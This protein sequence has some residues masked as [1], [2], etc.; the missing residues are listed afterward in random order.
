MKVFRYFLTAAVCAALL[1]TACKSQ[2]QKAEDG[3]EP[4]VESEVTEF[5]E[6][7]DDEISAAIRDMYLNGRFND[8]GYLEE[9]CSAELLQ[10]LADAYEYDCEPGQTVYAGWLFRSDSQDASSG[11]IL[12]L[13]KEGDWYYYEGNDGEDDYPYRFINRVRASVRD[14]VV[15]FEDL[16]NV[17]SFDDYQD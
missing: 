3:E 14:G 16:E 2:N 17:K 1:C 12:R 15:V 10:K 9:H 7:S 13:W 4:A 8:Y 5:A 6:E 11:K